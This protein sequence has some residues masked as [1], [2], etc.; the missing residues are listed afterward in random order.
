MS[1]SN[2]G[3]HMPSW[4]NSLKHAL[5]A[6]GGRIMTNPPA[7]TPR[8]GLKPGTTEPRKGKGR[9]KAGCGPG[10][11]PDAQQPD[12]PTA[13]SAPRHCRP[14][15][16]LASP[17]RGTPAGRSFPDLSPVDS[18]RSPD[19]AYRCGGSVGIASSWAERRAPTSRFTRPVRADHL[20]PSVCGRSI[21]AIGSA[22]DQRK[23]LGSHD[24]HP[25]RYL[26]D[27]MHLP[28]AWGCRSDAGNRFG[29]AGVPLMG[30]VQRRWTARPDELPS[31]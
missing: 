2:Q 13:A 30:R 6:Q 1:G 24:G 31:A 14:V 19:L 21:R 27:C 25:P 8:A 23:S 5:R 16:G 18:K 20:A 3:T 4:L 10:A 15:S 28:K 12:P 29:A 17:E 11:K 26:S 22:T 7:R 9:E